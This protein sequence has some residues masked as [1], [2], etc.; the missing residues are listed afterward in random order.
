M[1]PF[2]VAFALYLGVLAAVTW[3]WALGLVFFL[4]WASPALGGFIGLLVV[5][6]RRRP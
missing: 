5:H 3:W 2:V 4:V 6:P 1:R